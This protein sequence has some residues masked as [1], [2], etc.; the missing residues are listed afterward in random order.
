MSSVIESYRQHFFED[1]TCPSFHSSCEPVEVEP[2]FLFLGSVSGHAVLC[3][4][5]VNCASSRSCP[6]SNAVNI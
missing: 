4:K 2:R 3:R 1:I 6:E 5:D